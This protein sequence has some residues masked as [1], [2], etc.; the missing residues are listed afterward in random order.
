MEDASKSRDL[1][2]LDK[3]YLQQEIRGI[4]RQLDDQI[5]SCEVYRSQCLSLESKVGQLTDQ[6]LST[7]LSTRGGY[8]DRM[9][10][11]IQRLRDEHNRD[12]NSLK[13]TAKDIS[14]REN[15]VLRETMTS[16]EHECNQLRYR[17]DTLSQLVNQSQ[18]ELSSQIQDRNNIISELKTELKMKA[19]E[20]TR[21]GVS[22]EVSCITITLIK[23]I[24]IIITTCLHNHLLISS[25]S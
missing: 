24:Y 25:I 18:Q 20:L 16:L 7:Q 10:K 2:Q 12:M 19:F 4:Q 21:L 13:E 9:E 3:N 17:N 22:F 5:H 23:L 8:D 15:R 11:E 1:L 6:L 14:D